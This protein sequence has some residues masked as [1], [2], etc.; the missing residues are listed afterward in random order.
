MVARSFFALGLGESAARLVGFIAMLVVARRVG[1][2]MY[3]VIGVA[4]AIVLYLNRV[5]DG[6]IE[7]GLGVREVARDSRLDRFLPSILTARILVAS[8]VVL[9]VTLIGLVFLPEPDGMTLV[10]MA[11]TLLAVGGGARWVHIGLHRSANAALA[12]LAGQAVA[13]VLLIALVHGPGDVVRV[14][15]LMLVGEALTSITLLWWLGPATRRLPVEIRPEVIRPLLPR[16]GALVLS[17]LL[18]ILIYNADFIFL[19]VFRDAAAVGYYNAAYTLVT[20]FLNVG[21]AYS[22]SL[23]PSLTRLSS[24]RREQEHLYAG[25]MA[26]VFAAGLP[27]ALG[28]TLLAGPIIALL[29]GAGYSA[30]AEPFRL[31]IWC[32]PLCLLRDVPLMALQAAGREGKILRVTLFAAG[33]NLGLNVLLIPRWGLRGA[34]IATLVT[35]ATRMALALTF[36][37]RE[38]YGFDWLGRFWRAGLAG[39]GMAAFLLWGE[40]NLWMAIILG[41]VIYAIVLTMLGG[42]TWRRGRLPAL[43]V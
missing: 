38:G 43:T 8:V 37:A 25:A 21:T 36:V 14:P 40:L 41:A 33:V 10:V 1:A 26:Q 31:L 16:A 12:M 13:A 4:T 5:V 30:G 23:L 22:L 6:G 27:V 7:L 35:E 24:V 11:L 15:A 19:R 3:G 42:I 2:S 29:Y 28:G 9:V 17:A 20:F 32:I 39:L 18:G 34:A